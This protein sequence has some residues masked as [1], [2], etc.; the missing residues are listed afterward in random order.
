MKPRTHKC[1]IV[2]LLTLLS[3]ASFVFAS[4]INTT[5]STMVYVYHSNTD[6]YIRTA[7][8]FLALAGALG[9]VHVLVE[10]RSTFKSRSED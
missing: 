7:C 3:A 4:D 8:L 1:L 9:I 10:L 2:G 5:S 6:W